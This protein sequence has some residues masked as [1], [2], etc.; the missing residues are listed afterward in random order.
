MSHWIEQT[1]VYHIYPLGFCGCEKFRSEFSETGE[2]GR[3]LKVIEWIPHLK[4]IGRA[5]CRERV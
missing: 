2:K 1:N 3:I 5:S 4:K